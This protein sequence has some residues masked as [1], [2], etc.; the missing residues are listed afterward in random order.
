M[1]KLWQ[2]VDT[3]KLH[4]YTNHYTSADEIKKYNNAI[5]YMLEQ[6][7]QSQNARNTNT[8]YKQ[9]QISLDSENFQVRPSTVKGF[10]VSIN[11]ADI[12]LHLKKITRNTD[13][14]PII[15]IEFRSSFLHRFG[16]IKAIQKVQ[17]FIKASILQ[18]YKIKISEIHLH[19]DIQGYYFT[20]LDFYRIKTRTRNNRYF[21]DESSDGL[22]YQ[23]RSFQGFMLGG[24]DYLM[25]VYNKTKE[26]IKYP[27]KSFIKE[28]WKQ[29]KNY[30]ESEEVFRIEF[31]LRREKL[32]KMKLSDGTVLDGFEVIL[33]NLNN[34]WN[35]CLIDFSLRDLKDSFCIETMLG[36]RTLKDGTKKHLDME[37]IR[38]RFTRSNPHELWSLISTFNGHYATDTVTT[39]K[40]PF[41]NDFVYVQNQILGLMSTALSHYGTLRPDIIKEAFIKAEENNLK[42]NGCSIYETVMS[43]RLSRFNS[44]TICDKT[45]ENIETN[46]EYFMNAVVQ[47]FEDTF[48]HIYDRGVKKSFYETFVKKMVA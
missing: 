11:N 33:N 44:L 34:I 3:L 27:N 18:T 13:T 2:N 48:E 40:K 7:V 46:K 31:Q 43:K 37:T 26:I 25:R 21:D 41:T 38:K 47:V 32:K 9:F 8:S 14:N 28:C 16:Y 22:Y 36:Y 19:C 12:T 17:S 45:Y 23:G 42:K 15:K 1:V 20:M 24:G 39:F 29:N 35:Q 4:L 5:D 10:S 30:N 6:K